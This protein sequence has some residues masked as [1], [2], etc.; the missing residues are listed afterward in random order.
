MYEKIIRMLRAME[1]EEK[2]LHTGVIVCM[3]GLFFPWIG[4]QWAGTVQQWS[5]F[6]FYTG[7]IG[8]VVLLLQLFILA[9]TLS[10]LLG[11]PVLVKK[12]RRNF[13]RLALSCISTILLVMS[14]TVLL[15]L[16]SQQL[17]GA[18][19]R[20]GIYF[21]IVG[22]AIASLY[23]FLKYQEEQHTLNQALFQHPD[24]QIALKPKVTAV[25]DSLP[26]DRPPPPPPPTP[27]PAEDHHLFSNQ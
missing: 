15:R 6:G 22:S 13:V 27:P 11:G 16:T 7:Y 21:A 25:A 2:I 20:F 5:G 4:G 3:I 10:P 17:V 9:F 24:E 23:A 1:L 14:F 18:E 12:G 19:I 26:E 8:H